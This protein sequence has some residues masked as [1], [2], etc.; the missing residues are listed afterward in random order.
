MSRLAAA[1]ACA[2]VLGGVTIAARQDPLAPAST[3]VAQDL[4]PNNDVNDGTDITDVG[5]VQIEFGSQWTHVEVES[6]S[7]GSPK[8]PAS[9]GLATIAD[10]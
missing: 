10:K 1:V 8:S 9:L 3:T 5:L 6:R 2:C 4:P 7:A